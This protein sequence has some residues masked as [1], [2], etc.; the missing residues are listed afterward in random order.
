MWGNPDIFGQ[1]GGSFG[2]IPGQRAVLHLAVI[3]GKD[4]DGY[5]LAPHGDTG[6]H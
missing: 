6:Q 1:M 5:H 4:Q 3:M 2:H